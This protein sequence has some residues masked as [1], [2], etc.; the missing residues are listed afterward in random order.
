MSDAESNQALPKRR[1]MPVRRRPRVPGQAT[2]TC[3]IAFVSDRLRRAREIAA[4]RQ[5]SVSS[6]V[7]E[8]LGLWLAEI[9]G[10]AAEE[11]A[12]ETGPTLSL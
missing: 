9:E 12:E 11:G 4:L 1:S 10:A 8:A 2:E 5:V 3:S 6:V 7:D